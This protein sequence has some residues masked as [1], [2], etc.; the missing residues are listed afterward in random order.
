M[1]TPERGVFSVD[2]MLTGWHEPEASHLL[3]LEA[4]AGRPVLDVSYAAADDRG[5]PLARVRR[6]PPAPAVTPMTQR[7]PRVTYAT[8]RR[9]YCSA[10]ASTLVERGAQEVDRFLLGARAGAV[11]GLPRIGVEIV[12]QVLVAS[13][14]RRPRTAGGRPAANGW[15]ITG[16]VGAGHVRELGAPVGS[17]EAQ[18][19]RGSGSASSTSGSTTSRAGSSPRPARGRSAVRGRRRARAGPSS[20]AAR[21]RA[22]RRP[23]RSTSGTSDR[24]CVRC[25]GVDAEHVGD[26]RVQ[27]DVGRE[28]VDRRAAR[29]PATRR[30]AACARAR[31]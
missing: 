19:G 5:L 16:H 15:R 20:R 12:Q 17:R 11:L 28:R 24:P 30:A 1:I 31:E 21:G 3:M 22:P 25:A 23:R 29:H 18:L 7:G 13:R 4:V 27:V 10:G 14:R 8:P 2:G 26:R 6:R 9:S